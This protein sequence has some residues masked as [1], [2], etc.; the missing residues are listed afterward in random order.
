[1]YMEK[2]N[3]KMKKQIK[4]TLFFARSTPPHMIYLSGGG[5]Q[6]EKHGY[7]DSLKRTV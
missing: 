4:C 3:E 2:K 7:T 6:V 1:M 5:G